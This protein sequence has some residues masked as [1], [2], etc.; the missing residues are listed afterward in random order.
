MIKE[1]RNQIHDLRA[2]LDQIN[3]CFS[4]IVFDLKDGQK[5]AVDDIGDVKK[6]IERFS[7][8]FEQLTKDYQ[9]IENELTK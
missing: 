4:C 1:H 2:E 6:S 7:V 8:L 5:P 9:R 3:T